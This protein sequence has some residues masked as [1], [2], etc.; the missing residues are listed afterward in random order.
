MRGCADGAKTR[1]QTAL[2]MRRP[3]VAGMRGCADGAKTRGQTALSTRRATWSAFARGGGA[4]GQSGQSPCFRD[5]FAAPG[6][7]GSCWFGGSDGLSSQSLERGAVRMGENKGTEWSVPM[8][9][10]FI[11]GAG[12]LG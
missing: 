7:W 2:S 9:S 3:P 1:G 8:F 6:L 11:C 12:A 10:R 4:L 5:L